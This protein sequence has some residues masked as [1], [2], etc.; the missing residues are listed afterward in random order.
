MQ[1]ETYW[2]VQLGFY[3]FE[4]GSGEDEGYPSPGQVV[5]YYRQQKRWTLSDGRQRK[6]RQIDLAKMLGV[7]E[8][9]V[10]AMENNNESLDLVSR[11]RALAL[12]L[13][14]PPVLMGLAPASE[15]LKIHNAGQATDVPMSVKL[16]VSTLQW[17]RG[18]LQDSWELYYYGS[19][20]NLSTKVV[21]RIGHL[22]TCASVISEPQKPTIFEL[23][24][25]FNLLA[26]RIAADQQD[27]PKAFAYL[28]R[29]GKLAT[30]LGNNEL[31]AATYFWRGR[32]YLEQA[33]FAP[34]ALVL[35]KALGYAPSARPPLRGAIYLEAGLA[36]AYTAITEKD[37]SFTLDLFS[38]ARRIIAQNKL[39]DDESFVKLTIGR[40]HHFKAEALIALHEPD[41]AIIELD[42]AEDVT[43]LELTRRRAYIDILRA[44]ASLDMG[45]YAF[46]TFTAL[47]A[48]KTCK[49]INSDVN[50]AFI[51]D[52]Y[53]GLRQT[54]YANSSE[55][56]QLQLE[57]KTV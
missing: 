12:L 35:D 11:R 37:K 24:G 23:T 16:D 26:A 44:K 51:R 56:A 14:I 39:E 38:K 18:S 20:Q 29:A 31:L 25:R 30:Q 1:K 42:R 34:A 41:Q 6:C 13:G 10:R 5:K 53:A 32:T 28:K 21:Q 54:S 52:I 36:H 17:Y 8:S 3:P 48:L 2:W 15:L 57:L 33:E 7:S 47:E 50:I 4:P 45:D 46:A 27:Y 22:T 49:T 19:T 55:M 40:Y 43:G 9:W